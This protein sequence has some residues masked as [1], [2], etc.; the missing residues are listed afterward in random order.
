[1]SQKINLISPPDKLHNSNFTFNLVNT[2]QKEQEEVSMFLAKNGRSEE[3][4]VYVYNN[5][6]NPTWL[7]DVVDG[8][9]N[10]Y[11]NLDNTGDI[12]VK[13]TSYM[14]SKGNVYY[15]TKDKNSEE[16]YGIINKNLVTDVSTF[17]GKIYAER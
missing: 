7:L 2:T 13:Y 8:K 4:N 9:N 17:L 10:T 6:A 5:E 1:V 14:L 16:I 12:S 3:I 11:I 15:S